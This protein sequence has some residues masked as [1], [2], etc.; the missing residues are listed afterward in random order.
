MFRNSV[1]G[2][3]LAVLA[4]ST[5]VAAAQEN[6]SEVGFL[7][8]RGTTQ[9]YGIASTKEMKC[10]FRRYDGTV[11]RYNATVY[12]GGLDLGAYQNVAI[13][14]AVFAPTRRIGPSD[15]VGD[16]GGISAGGAIGLGI[17]ANALIGGSNNTIALNP[18]SGEAKTGWGIWAGFS[19]MELRAADE[20]RR[21]RRRR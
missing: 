14:W 21:K 3:A 7:A 15:L 5:G 17:G 9:T 19:R 20:P 11:F 12:L 10:L 16:Y 13:D 1:I 18:V 8:C 4:A 2:V 6:S